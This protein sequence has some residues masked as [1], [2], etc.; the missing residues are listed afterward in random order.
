MVLASI[1]PSFCPVLLTAIAEAVESINCRPSGVLASISPP[2]GVSGG[3]PI[4][5]D[6]F[7]N[8][9]GSADMEYVAVEGELL[10]QI[11][12]LTFQRDA[13]G[14]IIHEDGLPLM[15]AEKSTI[16][17]YQPTARIGWLNNFSFGNWNGSILFDGQIGGLI[18]SRSHALY[19]TSGVL[20]NNNDPNLDMNALNGRV[21]YDISYDAAGEPVY[22][23]VDAGG[24]VGPGVMYDAN[25]SLVPNTVEVPLRDYYYKFYGNWFNRDNVEAA[26]Y[27]ASFLK[28]REVRFGYTFPK[29]QLKNTALK[30]LTVSFVGRNLA[31]FSKVPTIDPETYSIRNG[32]FVQGYESTSMPSLRSIGFSVNANL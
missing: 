29:E 21:V 1:G 23:L 16:G 32:L 10:G 22:D 25:G 15:S 3:Y 4:V 2:D 6:L 11:K 7:P 30:G 19:N 5:A 12:G 17:S 9:G 13:D 20:E 8:D 26:T 31:L 27:D 28:L 18:Y 14:N 24:V